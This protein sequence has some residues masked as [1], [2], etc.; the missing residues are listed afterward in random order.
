MIWSAA[1]LGVVIFGGIALLRWGARWGSTAGDRAR[2]MPGD[3]YLGV[4]AVN[5]VTMTRGISIRAPADRVWPWMAQ[6]GR[7]AGW[8]SV[9]WLDN[10]RRTSA[11]HIVSWIPEPRLGDATAIGYLRHIDPGRSLA[12]WADG[13]RFLGA[14]TCLVTSYVLLSGRDGT[15]LISRMSASS[16][17]IATP[18]ALLVFRCID[19]VMATRQLLGIKS[20]VESSE[21]PTAPAEVPE[22]GRRDRYQLYEVIYA[23]G[24]RAGIRGREQAA[25]WRQA[26][27]A[28]GAIREDPGE[29]APTTGG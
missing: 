15:R 2:A 24:D 10:G 7:G 26:A 27:I 20:R 5:R 17:G 28:D 6:L 25:R 14:E 23:S 22:S 18:L 9:D 12:W 21:D 11:R 3:E 4:D 29:Q 13:V 1:A 8:Y 16:S 19:S